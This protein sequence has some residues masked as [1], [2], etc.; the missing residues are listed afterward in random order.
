MAL[1]KTTVVAI[2]VATCAFFACAAYVAGKYLDPAPLAAAPV[3]APAVALAPA[4]A[5]TQALLTPPS[6]PELVASLPLPASAPAEVASTASAPGGEISE[7]KTP[8]KPSVA[9][10]L[11]SIQLQTDG[12]NR[13]NAKGSIPGASYP[14]RLS[15]EIS[16]GGSRVASASVVTARYLACSNNPN[17]TNEAVWDPKKRTYVCDV[18]DYDSTFDESIETNVPSGTRQ[19]TKISVQRID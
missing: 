5:T 3:V 1:N 19:T 9:V 14:R 2:S 4:P 12:Y 16:T 18:T 13:S 15:I 7:P 6:A 17:G 8:T 10:D 11:P